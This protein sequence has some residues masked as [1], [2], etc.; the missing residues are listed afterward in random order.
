METIRDAD[1]RITSYTSDNGDKGVITYSD[2]GMIV[3]FVPVSGAET[4]TRYD[5]DSN[6]VYYSSGNFESFAEFRSTG[7][8]YR[9]RDK[10]TGEEWYSNE[11]TPAQ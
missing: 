9:H 7:K 8:V 10:T 11:E 2:T 5:N 1:G 4:I 6:V 3:R